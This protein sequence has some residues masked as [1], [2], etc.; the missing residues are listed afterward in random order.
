M[1]IEAYVYLLTTT[2]VFYVKAMELVDI[3]GFILLPAVDNGQ[4]L[5]MV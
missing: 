2:I 1:Y 5:S 3:F 4:L